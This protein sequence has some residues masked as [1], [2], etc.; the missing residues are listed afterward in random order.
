MDVQDDKLPTDVSLEQLE[1]A[2]DPIDVQDDTS[3]VIRLEQPVKV[4]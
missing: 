2:W 1:N 3:T 4:L